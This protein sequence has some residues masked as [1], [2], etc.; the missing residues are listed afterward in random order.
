MNLNKILER[1]LLNL[2]MDNNSGAN[3]FIEKGLDIIKIYLDSV[4]NPNIDIKEDIYELARNIIDSRPSMAP[5]INCMGYLIHDLTIITKKNISTR[6]QNL[7]HNAV[8]RRENLE[9]HFNDFLNSRGKDDL[10]LMLISYSSTITNLLLKSQKHKLKLYI[11][12]SRPLLEGRKVA[13]NLS[14]LFKTNLIIDA[15]MGKFIDQVDIVL[16][17]IDSILSNGS[18]I[19]KIGTYPLAVLANSNKTKVYAVG[20]TF[21]YNL[22]SHF[23][24]DVLIERKPSEEVFDGRR[25]KN[26][27]IFNYYFD[28][29]PAEF[30]TGIISD[31]GTLKVE[32]FLKN[33]KKTLPIEWFKY[34]LLNNAS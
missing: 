30:V 29:T 8:K 19:N 28:V 15:A 25:N 9:Q 13:D 10:R 26:L 34:F 5:L 33:V 22:R 11:L 12:E 17:G 32:D 2:T 14:K 7:E 27:E 1:K 16:V 4:K 21:K 3:E 24:Q 18:I 6:M 31:L 20:D 23:G